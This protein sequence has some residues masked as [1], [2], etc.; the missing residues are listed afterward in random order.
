MLVAVAL[1]VLKAFVKLPVEPLLMAADRAALA[2]AWPEFLL[3]LRSELSAL[4]VL[5]LLFT[6]VLFVLLLL[7]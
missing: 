7:A 3:M 1:D 5:L 6:S 4:F 2:T